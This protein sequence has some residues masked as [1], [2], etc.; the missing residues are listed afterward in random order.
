[1]EIVTDPSES[2][3]PPGGSAVTIGAYDGV[4][5]GHQAL[6]AELRRRAQAEGLTTAVVTFDR[7]PAAVVRPASA[8][9]LLCDLDQKLE[10]LEAAGVDRTVVLR[11][12]EERADEPAEDFVRQVIQ[13]GLDARLVVVGEDFHF[14]HGRKGNVALLTEMGAAD[15]FEV[16][17]MT[18]ASDAD[19]PGQGGPAI[20]ST[21][22]R[23]LVADGRVAEAAELLG[24]PHQVRGAVVHGDRRGGAD[25]GFP[26]ANLDVAP[27]IAL[28]AAGIY[29][30]WYERPDGSRWASA[31]SV[32][33][34][35][36]FYGDAGDL[37]VEAFLLDF[38]GDLYGEEGR[39][40]FVS[41]L[42]DEEAYDSVD[43]LVAQMHRD[44]AAAR[45]VLATAG[46]PT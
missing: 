36:T 42:R 14:G 19:D 21:R 3:P 34:R 35:P 25:L 11:F 28:P 1:M 31:V 37:L 16:E 39:L 8:P 17:G 15:G 45:Q 27:T 44:V 2:S 41:R 32:G 6:L 24:R 9:R 23:A 18:L 46:P 33:R 12:D 43:A 26:T 13:R 29:A 22:I 20:S 38:S 7:H 30:G 40:S 4:H 10:L 5:R